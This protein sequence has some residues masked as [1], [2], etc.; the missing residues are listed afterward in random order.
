MKTAVAFILCLAVGLV[1]GFFVGY[2][3]YTR[4]TTNEAVQQMLDG[5]ESSERLQAAMAVRSITLIESGD[6]SNAVQFLSRRIGDFYSS[7][8]GLTHN[9][10]RTKQLLV[11]IE[12]VASTNAVVADEI[13]R[14][15]Q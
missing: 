11:L 1:T 4:H 13:H 10:E 12:Q 14:K 9:D 2:R 6:G 7:Y 3:C 8:A 15:I 5:M